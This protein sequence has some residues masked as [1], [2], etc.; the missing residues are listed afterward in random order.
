[1]NSDSAYQRMKIYFAVLLAMCAQIALA[2]E[3]PDCARVADISAAIRAKN[4]QRARDLAIRATALEIEAA[5]VGERNAPANLGPRE[6]RDGVLRA[7][8]KV[9]R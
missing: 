3:V 1:M 7:C 4:T 9:A 8:L 2:Q 5:K 6:V